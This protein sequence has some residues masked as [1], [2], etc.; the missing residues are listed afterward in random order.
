MNL[1]DK[2]LIECIP[3]FSEGR[4]EQIIEDLAKAIKAV[5]GVKLL[6]RDAGYS[7]NRTVFT[8]AGE[9]EAVFEAAFQAILVAHKKIDMRKQKG[10]HP[11]I[12]ACDVCPFVPIQGIS[13]EELIPLQKKFAERVHQELKIPVFLYEDSASAEER[14]NL[15]FHRRGEYEALHSRMEM[16]KSVPDYGMEFNPRFGALVTGVRPFLIAYNIN[17]YSKDLSIAKSIASEIRES[18]KTEWIKGKKRHSPGLFPKVKAIGWYI[19]EFDCCQVSINITDYEISPMHLVFETCKSLAKKYEV[20]LNGSE[21]IGLVPQNAL[22]QAGQFYSNKK[23]LETEEAINLAIEKL[24]LSRL[25]PF[26]KEKRIIE[27]ALSTK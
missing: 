8:F 22:V 13:R 11:R 10:T 16:G 4:N 25:S 14:K 3:N 24:G 21:L 26:E 17:L 6:H 1:A 19:P 20:E 18:G 27:K 7:A 9:P 23:D 5:S 2:A 12:G 15:A